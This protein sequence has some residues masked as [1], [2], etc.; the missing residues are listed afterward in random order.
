[1]LDFSAARVVRSTDSAR[2]V[3]SIAGQRD[4]L[5][6]QSI[7][8][9]IRTGSVIAFRQRSFINTYNRKSGNTTVYIPVFKPVGLR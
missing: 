6:N 8:L 2:G 7:N 3:C 4:N 5:I 1:M 9:P